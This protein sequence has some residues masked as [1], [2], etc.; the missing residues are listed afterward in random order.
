MV[1]LED[2]E[3]QLW[4][5]SIIWTQILYRVCLIWL[6]QTNPIQDPNLHRFDWDAPIFSSL[7]LGVSQSQVCRTEKL[8]QKFLGDSVILVSRVSFESHS[9]RSYLDWFGSVILGTPW[10]DIIVFLWQFPKTKQLSP[11][12]F[13]GID[14]TLCIVISHSLFLKNIS[15]WLL[16]NFNIIP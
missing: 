13:P 4:N 15:P 14:R 5:C 2:M 11:T 9:Y 16:F 10:V 8:A 12:Y 7:F 3:I 1:F 6:R